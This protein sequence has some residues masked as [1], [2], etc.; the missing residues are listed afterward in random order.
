MSIIII[1]DVHIIKLVIV[2]SFMVIPGDMLKVSVQKYGYCILSFL[3]FV[4][5]LHSLECTVLEFD[6]K[7]SN[8]KQILSPPYI[9][10]TILSLNIDVLLVPSSSISTF[11][12]LI[13]QFLVVLFTNVC[14][15][16]TII[17]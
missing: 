7:A 5:A 11:W 4:C 2:V 13:Y 16:H 8:F 3:L 17:A 6:N 14:K 1:F 9:F 12:C 15:G 10:S